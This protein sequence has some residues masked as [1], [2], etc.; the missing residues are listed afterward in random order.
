MA[1]AACK[2]P[3]KTKPATPKAID[4]LST[5][6]HACEGGSFLRAVS[7]FTAELYYDPNSLG[8]LVECTA[9]FG[10][11]H[12]AFCDILRSM[13]QEPPFTGLTRAHGRGSFMFGWRCFL[14]GGPN[15]SGVGLSGSEQAFGRL[16]R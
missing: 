3:T 6:S 11:A 7:M 5:S 8:L 9:G 4:L 2:A 13:L 10:S 14:P 12:P 1:P 16:T 15:R